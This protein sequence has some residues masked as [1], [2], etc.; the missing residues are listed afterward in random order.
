[1]TPGMPNPPP[2]PAAIKRFLYAC[3]VGLLAFLVYEVAGCPSETRTPLTRATDT[4]PTAL[5]PDP[6]NICYVAV[7]YRTLVTCSDGAL[8]NV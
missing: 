7:D 8:P 1:M 3:L 4:F 2:Y 6:Q 5:K